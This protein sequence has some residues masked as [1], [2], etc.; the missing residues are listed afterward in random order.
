MALKLRFKRSGSKRVHVEK[1]VGNVA[2]KP[3]TKQIES[4]FSEG[5]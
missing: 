4:Q 3:A 1:T 2:V 5:W